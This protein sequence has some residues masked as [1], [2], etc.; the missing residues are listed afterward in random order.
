M[1]AKDVLARFV[2]DEKP[3]A[4]GPWLD[5]YS[6][7]QEI[8]DAFNISTDAAVMTLCGLCA[9]A[10]T[11]CRNKQGEIIEP[12]ECP[13]GDLSTDKFYPAEVSQNDL[14][15]WITAQSSAPQ[16]KH[17]D[18]VIA[19]MLQDGTI[20]RNTSWKDIYKLVRDR[21]NG[22][23]VTGGEQKPDKG[24]GDKQIQR[25]VNQLRGL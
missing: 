25:I 14:R 3:R 7:V 2:R 22:W 11:I 10:H 1:K 5:F 18:A 8:K 13:M 6:A 9:T 16:R 20:R 15:D 24:F 4:N 23:I 19:E 17:R 12:G 21:C